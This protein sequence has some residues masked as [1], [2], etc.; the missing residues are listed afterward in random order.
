MKSMLL[1]SLALAGMVGFGSDA[2]AAIV[3]RAGRVRVA[4]GRPVH[5]HVPP[6]IAPRP[7]VYRVPAPRPVAVPVPAPV[8][9]PSAAAREAARALRNQRV[10]SAINNAVENAVENA[11]NSELE[12]A[13]EEV[14][15][16][17]Q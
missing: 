9:V 17:N 16:A 14:A 11:V 1:C 10:R 4:V 7:L 6:R 12:E 15:S 5:V 2:S 13:L 8:V 3:V